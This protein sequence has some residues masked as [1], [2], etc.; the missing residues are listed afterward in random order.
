MFNYK[1]WLYLVYCFIR[2]IIVIPCRQLFFTIVSIMILVYQTLFNL[3]NG[4]IKTLKFLY[5]TIVTMIEDFYVT[6]NEEMEY[7]VKIVNED[8]EPTFN[9]K[10][11]LKELFKDIF[12]GDFFLKVSKRLN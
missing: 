1:K 4:T 6:V 11:E 12:N 7:F 3:I 5:S 10:E 8:V 9:F 2:C